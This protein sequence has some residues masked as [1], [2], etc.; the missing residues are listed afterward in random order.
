MTTKKNS[1]RAQSP[2]RSLRSG[3]FETSLTNATPFANMLPPRKTLWGKA[4]V[5]SITCN[6]GTR[7]V[8]NSTTRTTN[9]KVRG[10]W[11]RTSLGKSE[12]VVLTMKIKASP[13][14]TQSRRGASN[15]LR[16]LVDGSPRKAAGICP[17]FE[18][19]F[20]YHHFIKL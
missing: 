1:T 9:C 11:Q 7:Q 17:S 13:N 18:S 4:T 20:T 10:R 15:K 6:R 5:S 8:I 3:P 14:T 19:N 16:R 2:S 12:W